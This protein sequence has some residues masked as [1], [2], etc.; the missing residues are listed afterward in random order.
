MTQLSLA[1]V[2]LSVHF[3]SDALSGDR[4]LQEVFQRIARQGAASIVAVEPAPWTEL[5]R[6]GFRRGLPPRTRR[7]FQRPDGAGSGVVLSSSGLVL[8][9]E[10]IIGGGPSEITVTS[11][12]GNAYPAQIVARNPGLDLVLLQVEGLDA[13]PLPIARGGS[14]S[15]GRSVIVLGRSGSGNE[16]LMTTGIVSA[17]G[18]A[19]GK[20]IQ[21]DAGV[22]PGN[23]GGAVLGLDGRLLGIPG[24]FNRR[25]GW[26]SGVGLAA[27]ID[28]AIEWVEK[29]SGKLEP[30]E[31][32]IPDDEVAAAA[33]RFEVRVVGTVEKVF[34]TFVKV[35]GASGVVITPD[36]EVLTN[37]H[38]AGRR[39]ALEVTFPTGERFRARPLGVDALGDLAILQIEGG[40]D[41]PYLPLGEAADIEEGRF[42]LAF[43]NPFGLA[44][45]GTPTVTLGVISAIH[46]FQGD[47]GDS[48]QVDTPINPGNSGGP[49]VDLDGKLI[50]I[51]GRMAWRPEFARRISTGVGFAIP[52]TQIRNFLPILRKEGAKAAHGKVEGL[53]LEWGEDGVIVSE[54]LP[55][56]P[57]EESGFEP[58]DVI[59]RVADEPATTPDRCAG[60]LSTHPAGTEIRF[61][62]RRD[63]QVLDLQTK[64]GGE[65]FS[66]VGGKTR[67]GIPE[68]FIGITYGRTTMDGVAVW[69]VAPDSPAEKAGV[70][71]GDWIVAFGGKPA[72]GPLEIERRLAK[73]RYGD[74]VD[75][76]I[77]RGSETL[78]ISVKVINSEKYTP[79][80]N[81]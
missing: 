42:A 15:V 81:N 73:I 75:L 26:N 54:V 67:A 65:P 72:E 2:V 32:G 80:S 1:V 46:R 70:K 16:L 11:A 62:I 4:A 30:V 74:E 37:H 21:I 25:I 69:A 31:S 38:V 58:G 35:G 78:H 45:G 77:V 19:K 7:Y 8:T 12:E 43:G 79:P 53:K 13:P 33:R 22:H 48:I 41:F 17:L 56:S 55:D 24:L 63:G 10:Y 36:G 27:P 40:E 52:V 50:G 6:P 5:K 18:R 57:A 28:A 9:S 68:S 71:K 23:L 44:E 59:L 3:A 14:P 76:E 39:F 66:G 20:A 60:I 34:A 61:R 51:C 64:L 29:V 47:Y 49:L